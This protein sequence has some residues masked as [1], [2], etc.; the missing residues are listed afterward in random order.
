MTN[1]STLSNEISYRFYY[2]I[3]TKENLPLAVKKI[4]LLNCSA[5]FL[6]TSTV[7]LAIGVLSSCANLLTLGL[8]NKLHD[9]SLFTLKSGAN[10]LLAKPFGCFLQALSDLS[11]KNERYLFKDSQN[12]MDQRNGYLTDYIYSFGEIPTKLTSQAENFLGR[13]IGSKLSYPLLLVSCA[14]T[15]VVDLLLGVG[16]SAIAILTF[17]QFEKIYQL[18]FKALQAPAILYDIFYTVTLTINPSA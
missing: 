14:I 4:C 3:H 13:H 7:D 2:Y 18:A 16:A 9:Y 10:G 1:L 11:L 5:T 8:I 12:L 17:G 15:R 6:I